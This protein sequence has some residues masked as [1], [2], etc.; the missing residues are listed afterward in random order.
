MV[1]NHRTLT[2]LGRH[3]GLGV[4]TGMC[5]ALLLISTLSAVHASFTP[6]L[7]ELSNSASSHVI[8]T[9]YLGPHST[10]DQMTVGLVLQTSRQVERHNLIQALYNP[11]SSLYHHWLSKGEFEARFAPS[12]AHI[13]ATKNFLTTAG[14]QL[15]AGSPS[16]TLVLARGTSSRIE[17]A[18]HTRIADYVAADGTTFYANSEGVRVPASL[19][20][21]VIGVLGLTNAVAARSHAVHSKPEA[22]PKAAPPP[23]YGGGPSGSG[24]TPAQIAGIYNANPV[25]KMLKDRGQGITLGL[26]EL[27]GYTRHDIEKYEDQYKLPYVPL[28]DKPVLGG[29]MP[30]TTGGSPDYG[31]GEV[32]LDI[33]LQIALAPGIK[34]VQV[35]NAPNTEIGV[36]AEYLQIAKDN[37]ADATSS[38]W[39]QCEYLSTSSQKIAEFQAF[40]QMATQGQSIFTA[41]GDNGAFSCLP[42]TDANLT[43]NNELQPD[44]P[45][46]QPYVTAV[47][48]TSFSKPNKT[49]L[50]DPGTNLNPAYPGTTKETTWT[51]GCPPKDCAGGASGGGVS[52]YWGSVDYQSSGGQA[53]PGFIEKGQTQSGAYCGQTAGVFCREVPDVSLD[54]NPTTGY[55][56]YCTD[57]G[58]SFCSTGEFGKPGWIRLGGTSCAAPLW[59]AIDALLD[60]HAKGRTG[61][62]N[63]YLYSFDSKAGYAS[64]LH[65]ITQFDNGHY[66]AGPNY[67]MATG[68]GSADI[69]HLVKPS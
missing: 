50:F 59:A 24:L 19:S 47:G 45:S 21:S 37:T 54:S 41:S 4:L 48:G 60:T 27:S 62:L 56:I 61:L 12:Q 51:R 11:Q 7:V 31:A 28:Q 39:G 32:E 65:D 1:G 64:Q 17:A 57:K 46:G 8:G 10:D 40:T 53:V 44:D 52:R 20:G 9:R 29:A 68:L 23:P 43:G 2:F 22:G 66:A 33:E 3:P 67:D 38:S 55:S 18:F 42:Y 15:L 13:E 16:S 49:V 30:I 34:K 5:L 35:Y 58:D 6:P 25:Y 36:V 63:Y 14:L 26:F 69:F